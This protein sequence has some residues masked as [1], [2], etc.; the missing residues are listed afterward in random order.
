MTVISG[1]TYRSIHFDLKSS[2]LYI[3]LYNGLIDIYETSDE[4]NF[5][6]KQSLSTSYALLSASNFMGKIYAG[7]SDGSILVYSDSNYSLLQTMSGQ[8]SSNIRSVKFDVNGFLIHTC[9]SPPLVKIINTNN[10][11]FTYD[12][13]SIFT[14]T[15]E[16]YT[17]SKN[18]LW[19]GGNDGFAY[20][21][22]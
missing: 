20:F 18:R 22:S 17:D 1:D 7:T 19:V 3:A 6:L 11:I 21:F 9:V 4:L 2:L 13:S 14:F 16:T 8:C 5:V 10:S 15:Y 12:I